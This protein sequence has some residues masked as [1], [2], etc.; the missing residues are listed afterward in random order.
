MKRIFVYGVFLACAA[1]SNGADLKQTTLT[2]DNLV[3]VQK[4]IN[5]G[6]GITKEEAQW[7]LLGQI[8]ISSSGGQV[9]GKSVA[10]V[11]A[12]GKAAS[13]PKQ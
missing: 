1:C 3:A 9:V 7:Y 13:A 12:A 11:I 5:S 2:K 6:K 4:K 8:Q 10:E